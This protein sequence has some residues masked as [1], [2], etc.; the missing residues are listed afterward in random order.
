MASYQLTPLTGN[1]SCPGTAP[2]SP[3]SPGEAVMVLTT[4]P[5]TKP[6]AGRLRSVNLDK[7]V[8]EPAEG[9]DPDPAPFELPP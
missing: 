4:H 2:P 3:H 6:A 5:R 8:P 1:A 9:T 7:L